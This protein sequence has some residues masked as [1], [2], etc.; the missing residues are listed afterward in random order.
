MKFFLSCLSLAFL[1]PLPWPLF[2]NVVN[3]CR[4]L[5]TH[6]FFPFVCV[7]IGMCV[8]LYRDVCMC[9]CM[10]TCRSQNLS[11]FTYCSG[12][13]PLLKSRAYQFSWY[14]QHILGVPHH[15]LPCAGIKAGLLCHNLYVR[16]SN[17]GP[18]ACS[19]STILTGPSIWPLN[20]L[21]W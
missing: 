12:R 18:Y 4:S 17:S 6:V 21:F 13:A 16:D 8:C 9:T 3:D 11:F 7:C 2:R 1:F 10:H 14:T 19:E 20:A 5:L 15:C